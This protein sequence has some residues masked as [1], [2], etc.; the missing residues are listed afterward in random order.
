MRNERGRSNVRRSAMLFLVGLG[1][2]Q[3]LWPQLAPPPADGPLPTNCSGLDGYAYP[4]CSTASSV[5]MYRCWEKELTSNTT[6]S[7]AYRDVKVRVD[8]LRNGVFRHSA[9]AFWDGDDDQLV[10]SPN[11]KRFKFRTFFPSSG[12]W[13]WTSVCEAGCTGE[14]NG[15]V[16]SGSVAVASVPPTETNIFYKN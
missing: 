5:A 2:G 12:N 1:F 8:F 11:V 15:L 4:T 9:Y 14:T 7:N 6:Y 10:A 3:V 16:S 13:T